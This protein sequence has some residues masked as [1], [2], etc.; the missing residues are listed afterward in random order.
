MKKQI[1]ALVI[2]AMA[3][4]SVAVANDETHTTTT[5]AHH[6]DH[7]A[8]PAKTT[9]KKATAHATEEHKADAAHAKKH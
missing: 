2:A 6:D 7:A 9:K 3:S 1:I 5:E 8:A 4:I